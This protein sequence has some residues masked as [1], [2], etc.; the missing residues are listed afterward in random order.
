MRSRRPA[1]T[2]GVGVL[3]AAGLL[4]AVALAA[5][6]QETNAAAA[7]DG[8]STAGASAACSR[9]T[10]RAA[11][12]REHLLANPQLGLR[13]VGQLFCGPFAG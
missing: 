12:A 10:A 2:P 1:L 5:P 9:A 4:L 7:P 11:M 3:A 13:A 8:S 6:A